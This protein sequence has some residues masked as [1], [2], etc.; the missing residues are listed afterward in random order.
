MHQIL[1]T[2][3]TGVVSH[4]LLDDGIVRERDAL[5][6]HLAMTA[7]PDE[8]VDQRFAGD[9]IGHKGLDE[10]EHLGI[11]IIVANKHPLVR[12]A[13]PEM[14]KGP[15]DLSGH[16]GPVA[17][18]DGEDYRAGTD[19]VGGDLHG[20]GLLRQSQGGGFVLG[21]VRHDGDLPGLGLLLRRRALLHPLLQDAVVAD[22]VIAAGSAT[23][24][25]LFRLDH[26]GHLG[27]GGEHLAIST[28]IG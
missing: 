19:G 14:A 26:L 18:A 27:F 20:L 16:A 25:K 3:H 5:P 11:G 23:R 12:V 10:M 17:D 1:H 15:T 24:D 8:I 7:L 4:R 13:Q 28:G 9:A 2:N 6:V 22:L 21:S